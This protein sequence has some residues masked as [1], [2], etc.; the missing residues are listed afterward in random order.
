MAYMTDVRNACDISH[1][2]NHTQNIG[3]YVSSMTTY[4]VFA[5]AP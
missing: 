1:T 4:Y 2:I 5:S 3:A